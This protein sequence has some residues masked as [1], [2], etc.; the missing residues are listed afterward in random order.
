[1]F[2]FGDDLF[3][4]NRSTREERGA[5]LSLAVQKSTISL[6][7][8]K[9]AA[10][11]AKGKLFSRTRRGGHYG[12][13][14]IGCVDGTLCLDTLN[15]IGTKFCQFSVPAERGGGEGCCQYFAAVERDRGQS[16]GGTRYL[17]LKPIL[18]RNSGFSKLI[19]VK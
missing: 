2:I 3:F 5:G 16:G 6:D 1:M 19:Y 18:K 7:R 14:R 17:K 15:V 4:C 12:G 8:P 10:V 13:T 9:R 11:L